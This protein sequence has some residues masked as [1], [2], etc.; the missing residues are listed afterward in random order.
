M[1]DRI[2]N[3]LTPGMTAQRRAEVQYAVS[4]VLSRASSVDEALD[5]LLPALAEV[6][7]VVAGRV[8]VHCGQ[9]EYRR[10]RFSGSRAGSRRQASLLGASPDRDRKERDAANQC[11]DAEQR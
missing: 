10:G 11:D 4:R 1:S 6:I 2:R 8:G 3:P 7:R 5:A 9:A